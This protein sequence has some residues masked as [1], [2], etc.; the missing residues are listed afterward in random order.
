[1]IYHTMPH[2]SKRK[3]KKKVYSKIETNFIEVFLK[4]RSR[5]ETSLLLNDLL[6]RTERV[7]LSK[8]I[9]IV[10]MLESGYSFSTIER[11]LK[12]TKQTIVRFMKMRKSGKF[13]YLE[14]K[15][16]SKENDSLIEFLEKFLQAGL[17][18]RGKGRW[19]RFYKMANDE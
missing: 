3:L 14:A 16:E 15:K 17:P 11:T 4:F 7:M 6:T 19:A 12:V 2:V 8:R 13:R 1:M 5:K 10:L 9:A 18:P